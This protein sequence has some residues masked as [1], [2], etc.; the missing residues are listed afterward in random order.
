VYGFDTRSEDEV[1]KQDHEDASKVH[2]SA[3]AVQI[4]T[5]F[6]APF[7]DQYILGVLGNCALVEP[8]Q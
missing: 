7:H 8:V 4:P 2:N 1:S 5:A 3:K 6:T